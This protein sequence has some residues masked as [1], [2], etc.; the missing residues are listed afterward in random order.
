MSDNCKIKDDFGLCHK[1]AAS[2]QLTFNKCCDANN[3]YKFETS[4]CALISTLGDG[5]ANCSEVDDHLNCLTCTSSEVLM[6]GRCC[7]SNAIWNYNT[8]TVPSN[9][10]SD[11]CLEYV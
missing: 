10:A 7:P 1:C 8:C 6:Y 5:Y 4:A 3:Y 11:N 9:N 2:K